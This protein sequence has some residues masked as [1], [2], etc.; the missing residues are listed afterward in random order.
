MSL[1]VGRGRRL[2]QRKLGAKTEG[3]QDPGEQ[4]YLFGVFLSDAGPQ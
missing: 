2:V 3:R 4:W 1:V